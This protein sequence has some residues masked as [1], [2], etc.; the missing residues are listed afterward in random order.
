MHIQILVCRSLIF[1]W[2][3]LHHC[4]FL[5]RCK[6]F[7]HQIHE[8]Q[9]QIVIKRIERSIWIN[10]ND[11]KIGIRHRNQKKKL[12]GISD[13]SRKTKSFDVTHFG[14]EARSTS[15]EWSKRARV[16]LHYAVLEAHV[17]CFYMSSH[18]RHTCSRVNDFIIPIGQNL[19]SNTSDACKQCDEPENCK[20][21]VF[22]RYTELHI[23]IFHFLP[24]TQ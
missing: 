7:Y 11:L 1:H 8:Q 3:N 18:D 14:A 23:C 19:T 20:S 17:A 2:S 13:I 12:N 4:N 9:V 21:T 22:N 10:I 24:S 6:N 16:F 5:L 15:I